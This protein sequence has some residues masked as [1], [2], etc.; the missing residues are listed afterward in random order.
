MS[1]INIPIISA[2]WAE[3]LQHRKQSTVPELWEMLDV[4]NDP[5]VPGA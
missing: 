3:R 2:A 5:E 1:V 4:V